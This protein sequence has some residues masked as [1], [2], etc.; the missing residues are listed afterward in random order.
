[1]VK[2]K[3]I[4]SITLIDDVIRGN[5]VVLTMTGFTACVFWIIFSTCLW[6]ASVSR[7]LLPLH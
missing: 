1:L 3:Y 7:S 6:Y 4:P 2:D 5:A